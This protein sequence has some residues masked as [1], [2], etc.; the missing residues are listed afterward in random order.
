[1][2]PEADPIEAISSSKITSREL[3]ED[4][5]VKYAA[6]AGVSNVMGEEDCLI[7]RRRGNK[8]GAAEPRH[9]GREAEV[10][11]TPSNAM[12]V[13]MPPLTRSSNRSKKQ[14]HPMTVESSTISASGI[15]PM[16]S[17]GRHLSDGGVAV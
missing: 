3:G 2:D 10:I 6:I 15:T 17:D 4:I 14:A 7:R 1:M 13:S 16:P 12:A 5:K 9:R 11:G 8:K